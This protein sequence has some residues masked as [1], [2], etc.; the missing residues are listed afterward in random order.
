MG[1]ALAGLYYSLLLAF[2]ETVNYYFL[3]PNYFTASTT[4]KA[5]LLAFLVLTLLLRLH[6]VTKKQ[7]RIYRKNEVRSEILYIMSS[8]R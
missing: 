7:T 3:K 1:V 8:R 6:R 5:K 2:N 4:F